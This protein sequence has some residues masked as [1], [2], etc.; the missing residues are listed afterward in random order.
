[1]KF[2]RSCVTTVGLGLAVSLPQHTYARDDCQALIELNGES[3]ETCPSLS[4]E[5]LHP[6]KLYGDHS[7]EHL[8]DDNV[9]KIGREA[10][11]G[12]LAVC[13]DDVFFYLID[14]RPVRYLQSLLAPGYFCT[15]AGDD[16]ID[17]LKSNFTCDGHAMG[18]FPD[19]DF[20]FYIYGEDGNDKIFGG[21]TQARRA[22]R[23]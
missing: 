11:T 18:P 20:A 6:Y 15:G 8:E 5:L 12:R 19:S 21:S 7:L 4:H 13:Q 22:A 1:M 16:N 17:V 10:S 3:S 23:A 9:I 14:M 2:T